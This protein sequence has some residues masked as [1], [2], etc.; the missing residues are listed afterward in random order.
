M[1]NILFLFGIFLFLVL[2]VGVILYIKH[3][4]DLSKQ[5]SQYPPGIYC[6]DPD[7][8]N[9]DP[10]LPSMIRIRM[11]EVTPS[12]DII[13]KITD[14]KD[15]CLDDK[16]LAKAECENIPGVRDIL[17]PDGHIYSPGY[18]TYKIIRC[19]EGTV[20]RENRCVYAENDE[21]NQDNNPPNNS[22]SDTPP[23]PPE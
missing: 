5:N 16:I 17:A 4:I 21:E 20:C 10:M 12:G 19:P 9:Y 6:F 14:N 13:T 3:N 18:P 8:L 22:D 11:A 15:K 7:P 23:P 1:K 2:A